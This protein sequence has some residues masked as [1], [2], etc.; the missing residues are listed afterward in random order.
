MG[1]TINAALMSALFVSSIPFSWAL[2]D[3]VF[4]SLQ[5]LCSISFIGWRQVPKSS[6]F[7]FGNG[8]KLPN[9][10]KNPWYLFY[11][12]WTSISVKPIRYWAA[13]E[14]LWHNLHGSARFFFPF[15]WFLTG[16]HLKL[17][18]LWLI[19]TWRSMNVRS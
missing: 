19:T 11:Y 17:L 15:R 1:C 12:L 8:K 7:S 10:V 6:N 3:M 14:P 18:D 4:S 2:F 16:L 5:K 13:F 9:L